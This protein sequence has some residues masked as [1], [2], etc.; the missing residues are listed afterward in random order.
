MFWCWNRSI[1]NPRIF[2]GLQ[3]NPKMSWCSGV[4][5][6]PL[7]QSTICDRS[8]ILTIALCS[9][10]YRASILRVVMIQS[11]SVRPPDYRNR[12]LTV[13]GSSCLKTI[14]INKHMV[15]TWVSLER[16]MWEDLFVSDYSH[17]ALMCRLPCAKKTT[18]AESST[19]SLLISRSSH[20]LTYK[21][22]CLCW[23]RETLQRK[24]HH[25]QT[26]NSQLWQFYSHLWQQH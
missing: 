10:Q 15:P 11:V 5:G 1:T 21:Y 12:Q 16:R 18:E 13:D 14:N 24:T 22:P 20:T 6:M 7:H 17:K 26:I 25:E 3:L 2:W 23:I 8:S 19:L 4:Y 9:Y